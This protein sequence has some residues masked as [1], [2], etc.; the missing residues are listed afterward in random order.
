[1]TIHILDTRPLGDH[2][3]HAV[4]IDSYPVDISDGVR[5]HRVGIWCSECEKWI[6]DMENPEPLY[7]ADIPPEQARHYLNFTQVSA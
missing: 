4:M 5:S 7:T 1:M 6:L 3:G 2:S